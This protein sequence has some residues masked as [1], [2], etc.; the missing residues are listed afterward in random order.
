[1]RYTTYNDDTGNRETHK[2]EVDQQANGGVINGEQCET[3][4][5]A[6]VGD[7]ALREERETWGDGGG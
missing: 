3:P 5:L 1:M 2:T 4:E 6:S 7:R